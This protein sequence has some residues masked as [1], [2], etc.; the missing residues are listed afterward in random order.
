M[1]RCEYRNCNEII[2]EGR[3]DKKYCSVNCKRNEKKY[4][5]RN[6]KKLINEKANNR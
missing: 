5:Q 2:K 1:K 4:R 3:S 6:K